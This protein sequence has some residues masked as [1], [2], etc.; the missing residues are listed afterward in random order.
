MN[1]MIRPTLLA[2]GLT[3]GL[4]ACS[5]SEKASPSSLAPPTQQP[6]IQTTTLP[7][8]TGNLPVYKIRTPNYPYPPFNIYNPDNTIGGLEADVL[9]AVA[10]NQNI[11][12][13]HIPY[14]WDAIFKDLKANDVSMVGGGLVRSD[15]ETDELV[16]SVPYL[17]APD[18]VVAAH[19]SNLENWHTRTVGLRESDGEDEDVIQHFGVSP[20]NIVHVRSQ[21]QG[22]QQLLAGNIATMMSDCSVIRYYIKQSF[23][24]KR[25]QFHLQEL[26]R[27][28][29]DVDANEHMVIGVRKDQTELLN[30]IN[31]GIENIKKNGELDAILQKWQ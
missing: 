26:T 28:G 8:T 18:C 13:E 3:L 22:L 9:E 2:I 17:R 6:T 4:S 1:N 21:Y 16:A 23:D 14:I 5:D 24:D 11:K 15:F 10:K 12:I 20:K 27:K 31:Q 7:P 30:K 19:P 29:D 25:N